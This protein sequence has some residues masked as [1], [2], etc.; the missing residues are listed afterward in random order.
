[1]MNLYL[2]QLNFVE[3]TDSNTSSLNQQLPGKWSVIPGA[4]HGVGVRS[5]YVSSLID[6]KSDGTYIYQKLDVTAQVLGAVE[7]D[8]SNIAGTYKWSG[9]ILHISD[10]KE[11]LIGR[12]YWISPNKFEYVQPGG[13]KPWLFERTN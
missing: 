12:V 5:P 3:Q 9:N 10:T 1:M 2:I 6:F 7:A 13:Q 4:G 8:E 11:T